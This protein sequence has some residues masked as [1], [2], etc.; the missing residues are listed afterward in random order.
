MTNTPTVNLNTERLCLNFANTLDWHASEH[1]VETLNSYAD[2]VTWSRDA[3]VLSDRAAKQLI[4]E[5][6]RHPAEATATLD[7]ARTLREAM[8]EIFV[9]VANGATPK[10]SELETVNA[11]LAE[12]L[13]R[14]R[15]VRTSEGFAWNWGGGESDLDQMLWWVIRSAADLMTSEKLYR[16]GQCADERGCGWLFLDTSKNRTRRWCAMKDCGNR[17]KARRYYEKAKNPAGMLRDEK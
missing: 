4:N 13:S 10:S 7:K 17:A 8:Y 1:P 5:A 6:N 16:V 2:L 9:A 3:G 15:L 11:V 12:M 14:S